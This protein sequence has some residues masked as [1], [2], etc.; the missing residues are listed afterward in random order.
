MTGKQKLLAKCGDYCDES[1]IRKVDTFNEKY[2]MKE[3]G[4]VINWFEISTPPGRYSV[5]DTIGDI[6]ST[7]RGKIFA[8]RLLL[9]IKKALSSGND[10]GK[11]KKEGAKIAGFK[12]NKTMLGIAKGFTL[13]RALM[14][15]GGK[16]TKEDILKINSMLN[17]I[18]KK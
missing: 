8:V 9:I 15:M 6:I 4:A 10:G 7:F 2:R 14:M 13:K 16:F 3:E 18:K 17:K 11:K 12:I 1:I 5:N